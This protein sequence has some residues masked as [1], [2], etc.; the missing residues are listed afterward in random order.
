MSLTKKELALLSEEFVIVSEM[1][2]TKGID[3]TSLTDAKQ[4]PDWLDLEKAIQE[5]LT[6]L[7]DAGTWALVKPPGANIV[8]SK[9][10]FQVKK[11]AADS[12]ICKK[13]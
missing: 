1:G 9:W 5:E 11:D 12:I 10:V 6:M 13:A 7:K 2:E 4:C 8:G 3:P